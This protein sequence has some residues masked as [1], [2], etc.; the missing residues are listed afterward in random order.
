[1]TF[2]ISSFTVFIISNTFN[3]QININMLILI[4]Y[5]ERECRQLYNNFGGLA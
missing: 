2:H 5:D 4:G 1:M 3:I